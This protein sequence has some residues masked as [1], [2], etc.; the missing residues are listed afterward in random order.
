MNFCMPILTK[1]I[2][3]TVSAWSDMSFAQD[4]QATG[5]EYRPLNHSRVTM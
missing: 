1:H 3:T 4:S 2:D 5:S